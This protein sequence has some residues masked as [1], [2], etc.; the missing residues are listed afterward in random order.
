MTKF[1]FTGDMHLD[2]DTPTTIARKRQEE[3]RKVFKQIIDIAIEQHVYGV[4]HAGD[5]F[6]SSSPAPMDVKFVIEQLQRLAA[7]N[8][9]F[10]YIRGN[11][12]GTANLTELFR[13]WAGEYV[14]IPGFTN[15]QLIDPR[16]DE[17][18]KARTI[19]YRDVSGNIRIYGLGYFHGETG[20][21]MNKYID[22]EKIDQDKYNI[23]L[24]HA[25][26]LGV[27]DSHM[28]NV[29]EKPV[30]SSDIIGLNLD[31]VAFG[32]S[33]SKVEPKKIDNTIFF[34]PGSPIDWRFGHSGSHGV[35]I[36]DIDAGNK[37]ASFEWKDIDTDY[38][39]TS[40]MIDGKD[41][42]RPKSWY[43]GELSHN[44]TDLL[45]ETTKPIILRVAFKGI[46]TPGSPELE[47]IALRNFIEEKITSKRLFFLDNVST[48]YVGY[49]APKEVMD[50]QKIREIVL[51]EDRIL[52]F[53]KDSG[54]DEGL[55][56]KLKNIYIDVN[57][58]FD[59]PKNLTRTGNLD[60]K[61][62]KVLTDRIQTQISNHYSTI[63]T[64]K[65]LAAINFTV[66]DKGKALASRAT[67]KTTKPAKKIG[68][69][70]LL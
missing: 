60:G 69:S 33:H 34:G 26:I 18:R 31:L 41:E 23:L 22:M 52:K 70:T 5:L 50:I 25:Y 58:A 42:P 48:K 64:E 2:P 66:T 19:G 10:F 28:I 11:H 53:L 59:D 62:D 47:G 27:N 32:H 30:S 43:E 37:T 35:Y 38:F 67:K 12:E 20:A 7:S 9:Q 40:I 3:F 14:D 13:G 54:V 55:A 65:D 6:N 21:V 29:S 17:A 57:Q 16:F 15:V 51:D 36:V 45:Q 68:Q 1:L 46:Y 56:K 44:L 8:I 61:V 63:V 49:K 24:I 39:M 4:C